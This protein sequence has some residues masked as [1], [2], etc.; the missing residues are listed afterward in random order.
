MCGSLQH[1]C[2]VMCSCVSTERVFVWYTF[3]MYVCGE[4]VVW[5][6]CA[7]CSMYGLGWLNVLCVSLCVCVVYIW[8]MCGVCVVFL[9]FYFWHL[10]VIC[11]ES[12]EYLF[13]VCW[14]YPYSMVWGG[15]H[16]WYVS[17]VCV[18]YVWCEYERCVWGCVVC[19][20]YVW[21]LFGVCIGLLFL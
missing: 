9:W 7:V 3:G 1:M 11:E 18:L 12:A 4:C 13:C 17:L 10:C 20:M 21:C 19:V 8:Y 14:W 2:K 6:M 5:S 15:L 16:V